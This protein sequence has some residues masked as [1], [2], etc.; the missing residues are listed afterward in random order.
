MG[1]QTWTC[2]MLWGL[3]EAKKKM[4]IEKIRENG[5]RGVAK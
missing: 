4:K 5:G 3:K 2:C 1:K